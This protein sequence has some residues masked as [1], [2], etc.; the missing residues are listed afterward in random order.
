MAAQGHVVHRA[1]QFIGLYT[2]TLCS[3]HDSACYLSSVGHQKLVNTD[4]ALPH[5]MACT[6]Q[7]ASTRSIELHK[8]EQ[9]WQALSALK[10]PHPEHCSSLSEGSSERHVRRLK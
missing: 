4:W 1:S 9:Q 5:R 10:A 6:E 8:L 2:K 7:S 3:M